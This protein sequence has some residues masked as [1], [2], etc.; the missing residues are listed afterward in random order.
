MEEMLDQGP[1]TKAC[2]DSGPTTNNPNSRTWK[3]I[4]TGPK[5]ANP[6]SEETHAG[7]KRGAQDHAKNEMD[8]TL[9][10]KK[11][12]T[13][14]A[15]GEKRRTKGAKPFRFKAKWLRDLRCAEVVSDAWEFGL[16]VPM[17]HPLQNC[18]SSCN[19]HLTQWNK[20]EFGHLGHQIKTLQNRLQILEASPEHNTDSICVVTSCPDVGA[21]L[22]VATLIDH[23]RREWDLEA[24]QRTLMSNDVESTFSIA[25]SSTLPKDHLIWVLTPSGKFTVKLVY[26]L[27]LEE[28]TGHGVEES[29][30]A[31]CMK[32]EVWKEV[33]LDKDKVMDKFPEFLDL[34]WY[35]RNVKQ[36]TGE[37]IGLMVTTA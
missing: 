2:P 26:K 34:L 21:D 29:S 12:E 11:T 10:K 24:L 37:D 32:E 31:T 36:W 33:Y 22:L 4:I 8:T 5:L 23:Q 1:N 7:S 27:A 14:V 30:N 20:R 9:K 35:A 6:N 25:L 18:I 16:C 28:R 13:D 19:A 17:G 15:E 3:R